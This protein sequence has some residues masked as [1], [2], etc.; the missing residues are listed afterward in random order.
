MKEGAGPDYFQRVRNQIPLTDGY[1]ARRYNQ[2]RQP[3]HPPDGFRDPSQI[4]LGIDCVHDL[5]SKLRQR[6]LQK[7]FIGIVDL[8]GRQRLSR[9]T[10]LIPRHHQP[11]TDLSSDRK[12]IDP[13]RAGAGKR[14]GIDQGTLLNKALSS[15]KIFSHRRDVA[16]FAAIGKDA[17]RLLAF[18]RILLADDLIRIIRNRRAGHDPNGLACLQ[19]AGRKGRIARKQTS[20]DRQRDRH[21]QRSPCDVRPSQGIAIHGRTPKRRLVIRCTKI[22]RQHPAGA[23][24]ERTQHGIHRGGCAAKQCLRLPPGDRASFSSFFVF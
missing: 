4:I 16:P 5:T 24:A 10:K 15:G 20:P 13:R 19:R 14:I 9:W 23:F 17:Y 11:G 3:L 2:I 1:A 8:A 21:F 6:T 12:G 7:G 22:F 18:I